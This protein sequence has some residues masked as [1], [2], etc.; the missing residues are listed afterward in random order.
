MERIVDG[1]ELPVNSNRITATRVRVVRRERDERGVTIVLFALTLVVLLVFTAMAVDLGAVYNERRQDQTAS[2][3]GALAGAQEATR[4]A[5]A[6]TVIS[7]TREDVDFDPALSAWQAAWASCTDPGRTARGYTVRSTQSDCISFTPNNQ[8]MRVRI[9]NR[10]VKT[11]FGKVVGIDSFRV[12]AVSEV[13][14][15]LSASG[16]VIPY[17]LPSAG[18]NLNE[19]CVKSGSNP[20]NPNYPYGP[21]DG[22]VNGNFGRLDIDVYGNFSLGYTSSQCGGNADNKVA[23]NTALGVD[24]PLGKHPNGN[25][26]DPATINDRTNCPNFKNSPNQLE[27]QTGNANSGMNEGL[28]AS[29]VQSTGVA[30][31]LAQT[32]PYAKRSNVRT[33]WPALDNWPLW[34]FLTPGLVVGSTNLAVQIPQ[35]CDPLTFDNTKSDAVIGYPLGAPWRQLPY[36]PSTPNESKAH[37]LV[38]MNDYRTLGYTSVL[39]GLDTDGDPNDRHFDIQNSK[40]FAFVPEMWAGLGNGSSNPPEIKRFAA[41][42][43][44]DLYYGNCNAAGCSAVFMPGETGFGSFPANRD[45]DAFTAYVFRDS[46][47]PAPIVEDAPGQSKSL[48][49]VLVR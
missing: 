31:R 25:G 44:S 17:G 26:S 33:G 46:M 12:T 20:N 35:S 24:H 49:Y 10:F 15:E 32:S 11:S 2:D 41:V 27:V 39:F 37:M 6:D 38:C 14:V 22:P 13:E 23:L 5:A 40:R 43:L 9:P 28:T 30:G 3:A 42:F 19:I 36:P 29:S 16:D 34:K 45:I 21:C 47:L 48:R 4:T 7:Y 8:R 18:A 1:G